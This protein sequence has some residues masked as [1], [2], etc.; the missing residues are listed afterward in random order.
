M[1]KSRVDRVSKIITHIKGGGFPAICGTHFS[2]EEVQEIH[3]ILVKRKK[4]I[5]AYFNNTIRIKMRTKTKLWD[6][7]KMKTE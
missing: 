6:E 1:E 7:L 4:M 3:S 2:E 5:D